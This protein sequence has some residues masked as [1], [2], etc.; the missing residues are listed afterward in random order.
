MVGHHHS[1]GTA[2]FETLE[3][4]PEIHMSPIKP[5][6]STVIFHRNLRSS[7]GAHLKA[8]H[9]FEHMRMGWRLLE[10]DGLGRVEEIWSA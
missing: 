1:G 5:E 4:H 3:R 6:V 8:F 7:Q 9:Y 10:P 2:L